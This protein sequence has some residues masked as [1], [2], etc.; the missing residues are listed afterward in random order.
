MTTNSIQAVA[1]YGWHAACSSQ[2]NQK[3][4]PEHPQLID[5]GTRVLSRS[6]NR[7][8]MSDEG[9]IIV[10]AINGGPPTV[11]ATGGMNAQLPPNNVP[12][13]STPDNSRSAIRYARM[14]VT[15]GPGPS[16]RGQESP[17][18]ARAPA[19]SRF[20]TKARWRLAGRSQCGGSARARVGGP[21]GRNN[22]RRQPKQYE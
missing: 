18:A 13:T 7:L 2:S 8:A 5:N 21:E 9:K 17:S 20:P 11:L 22:H 14:A 15:G 4:R 16:S 12:C 1:E 3:G 10:Q 19:T 6:C